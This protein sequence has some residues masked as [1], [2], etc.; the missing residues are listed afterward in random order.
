M[1]VLHRL[2]RDADGMWREDKDVRNRLADV[3]KQ[4]FPRC[5]ICMDEIG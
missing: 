3:V 5:Q 1:D 2:S 4:Y